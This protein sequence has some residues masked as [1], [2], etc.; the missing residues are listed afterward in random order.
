MVQRP[1]KVPE[2]NKEQWMKYVNLIASMAIDAK[3]GKGCDDSC[4]VM[5][6]R[7]IANNMEDLLK[8]KQ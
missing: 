8:P 6:L 7:M 2:E 3:M 4:F 5:N 1:V